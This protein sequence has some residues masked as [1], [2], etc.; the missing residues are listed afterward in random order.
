MCG[1][2]GEPVVL[3]RRLVARPAAHWTVERHLLH[4]DLTLED[5]P[6]GQANRSLKVERRHDLT[7]NDLVAEV[8]RKFGD[9]VHHK[10]T[11]AL[12][13]VVPGAVLWCQLMWR[14]LHEGGGDVFPRRCHG[15]VHQRWD[16]HVQEWTVARVP[17]LCVVVRLLHVIGARGDAH[18]SHEVAVAFWRGGE[19]GEAVKRE[20][21]LGAGAAELEVADGAL[22]VVRQ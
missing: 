3:D 13:D 16:Q 12:L 18:R 2:A 11:E 7:A 21:H 6:F 4:Q 20:V 19:C 8:R 5:V 9:G 17:V 1:G 10:V 22:K 15:W 14:V